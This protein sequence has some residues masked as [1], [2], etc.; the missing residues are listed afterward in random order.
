MDK[1]TEP[2]SLDDYKII[3]EFAAGHALKK[4]IAF[5]VALSGGFY[6]I[7]R[8]S[9]IPNVFGIVPSIFFGSIAVFGIF[10]GFS[11][12]KRSAK[13]ALA[14]LDFAKGAPATV[15]VTR[16]RTIDDSPEIIVN[17][18]N[19]ASW[20]ICVQPGETG[21][22]NIQPNEAITCTVY[23]EPKTGQPGV[24]QIQNRLIWNFLSPQRI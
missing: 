16:S 7:N 5:L 18:K 13:N 22:D 24:I 17:V 10:G 19:G 6:L 3:R 9:E 1:F 14:A 20:K 12:T 23:F 8:I 11:G 21:V 15:E 2:K 4:V